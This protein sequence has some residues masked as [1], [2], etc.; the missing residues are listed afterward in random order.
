M[1][2]SPFPPASAVKGV[3]H[4]ERELLLFYI[5]KGHTLRAYSP[6]RSKVKRFYLINI[7]TPELSSNASER[8]GWSCIAA[9]TSNL[10]ISPTN[11]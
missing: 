7:A 8:I 11:H 4:V 6:Y 9:S 10:G 3:N 1:G 5:P 2:V